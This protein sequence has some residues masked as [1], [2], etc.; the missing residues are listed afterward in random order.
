MA[1]ICAPTE[2]HTQAAGTKACATVMVLQALYE[3]FTTRVISNT[4]TLRGEPSG[5][6]HQISLQAP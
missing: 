1:S 2:T 3:D 5:Q 4:I 6:P